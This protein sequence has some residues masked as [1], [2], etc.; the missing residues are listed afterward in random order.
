MFESS[1]EQDKADLELLP[2]GYHLDGAE[3]CDGVARGD[4][5]RERRVR[6]LDAPGCPPESRERLLHPDI[7]TYTDV[8]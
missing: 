5:R 1:P 2:T 6:G 4:V 8:R 7:K 3:R